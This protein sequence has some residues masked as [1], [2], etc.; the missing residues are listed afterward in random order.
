MGIKEIDEFNQVT[1][2]ATDDKYI[3]KQGDTTYYVEL[4]TATQTYTNKTYSNPVL[5]GTITG[6][7][8]LDED[9]LGSDSDTALATQQS[10]KAY[11][12]AEDAAADAHITANGSSHTYIDQDVTTSGTPTFDELTV[13]NGVVAGNSSNT[14]FFS[15]SAIST[16]YVGSFQN[17]HAT[18]PNGVFVLFPAG[19]PNNTT[20]YFLR[21]Q[22]STQVKMYIY[23]NGD[24]VNRNNS[25]GLLS[26]EK[27]KE[28]IVD[29]S[30]KLEDILKLR[31]RNYNLI[32]DPDLKQV[33]FIAQ[34][35][36][37]VFP[38]LVVDYLLTPAVEAVEAVYDEQGNEI[39]PAIEA[40]E[41]EK[42]K[43][44]KMSVLTPMLVKAIQEQQEI[45]EN[46]TERINI[47]EGN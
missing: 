33:G 37:E 29:A 41:E 31:L 3:L 44:I 10:I 8:V 27:L 47:L 21:C 5:N 25:Y 15:A 4:Q 19:S 38:A 2:P 16:S 17:Y 13:E 39:S 45:I 7:G 1:T 18:T 32:D 6:T 46:L 30:P 35:F 40:A 36:E 34:E 12:D 26:D 9:D 23:S 11:V 20:Q 42:A 24:L 43:G 14:S 28:N 22:D